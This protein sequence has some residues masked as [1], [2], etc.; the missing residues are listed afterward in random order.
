MYQFVESITDRHRRLLTHRRF[1]QSHPTTHLILQVIELIQGV[2]LHLLIS[3][4]WMTDFPINS[5][6]KKL[7][8]TTK[9]TF[10]PGTHFPDDQSIRI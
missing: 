1:D 6:N 2:K 10:G 4:K 3:L 7:Q 5:C 9:N 8:Q